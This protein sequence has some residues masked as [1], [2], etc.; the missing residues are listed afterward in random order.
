MTYRNVVP[1]VS[2]F[3][4]LA[5]IAIT[6]AGC[7][8]DPTQGA[9]VDAPLCIISRIHPHRRRRRSLWSSSSCADTGHAIARTKAGISSIGHRF[10]M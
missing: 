7:F 5:G 8:D 9:G 6:T 10:M 3:V 2:V 1:R 4:T